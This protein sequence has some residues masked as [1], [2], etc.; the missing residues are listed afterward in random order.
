[1][2]R[3]IWEISQQVRPGIPV[4]PGDTV[5]ALETTWAIG[6]GCPVNVSRLTLSTHTGTHA[7]APLHYDAAGDAIGDLDMD[8]Y[9]GRCQVISLA[10]GTPLAMV[11][12]VLPHLKDGVERVLLHSFARFPDNWVSDFTAIDAVL[13]DALAARGVR[14]IGTDAPSIDPETSKSLDAHKAVRRRDMRILEGLVLD[15]VPD[16][17]YELIALPIRLM[18]ADAAPVR[19]ILRSL[20]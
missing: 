12:H 5:Y 7:D 6:P 14:L 20:C 13:I 9:I 11:E 2:S 17:E 3:R 10:P 16:G 1:M 4:W 18:G 15:D 8:V 19:A